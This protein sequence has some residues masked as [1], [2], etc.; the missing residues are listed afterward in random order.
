MGEYGHL[1][2][3]NRKVSKNKP[4]VNI[5]F[6]PN[7]SATPSRAGGMRKAP[8]RGHALLGVADLFDSS[9]LDDNRSQLYCQP[10]EPTQKVQFH[11]AILS[12]ESPDLKIRCALD[13]TY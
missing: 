11:S 4:A 12:R 3:Y 9:G 5:F 1:L 7:K 2:F 8:G 6:N 13:F 10:L